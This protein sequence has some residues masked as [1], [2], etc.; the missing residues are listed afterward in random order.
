MSEAMWAPKRPVRD[1]RKWLTEAEAETVAKL[2][3]QIDAID[4][5]I[6]VLQNKRAMHIAKRSPIRERASQRALYSERTKEPSQ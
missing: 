1:W 3:K 5:K 4:E 2:D 6:F